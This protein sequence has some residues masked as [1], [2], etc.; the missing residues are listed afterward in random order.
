[1]INYFQKTNILVKEKI[2]MDNIMK[3]SFDKVVIDGI[4]DM[5]F[6]MRV[7][8]GTEFVYDFLN[9]SAMEKTGL[10]N[11]I[12]CKI[13]DIYPPERADFLCNQYMEVVIK[14]EKTIFEDAYISEAGERFF[15]EITLNP[16]L[17]AEG[18]CHSIIAIVKDSTL[19]KRALM[20]VQETL[21]K[22]SE[23]NEYYQSLFLHNTDGIL[24]FN[25]NGIIIKSNKAIEEILGYS[26]LELIGKSFEE[27]V[28]EDAE[29]LDHFVLQ[30]VSGNTNAIQTVIQHKSGTIVDISFKIVPLIV[31][32][33]VIGIYGILRDITALIKAAEKLEK[34]EK[35]FRIMAEN[36][37]DLIT[38]INHE[39]NITYVSPSYERVLGYSQTDFIGKDLFHNIRS[40]DVE[41]LK[42]KIENSIQT[43]ESFNVIFRQY[44]NNGEL[45]WF[46][47][48]GRPV[49]DHN[50]QFEYLVVQTRDINLR[51]EY[52]S[53]LKY[54]A[55]HDS[56]TG[57][58]NRMLFNEEFMVAKENFQKSKDGLAL[59][60]LDIDCFKLINDTFGHDV[61]DLVIKEFSQRIRKTIRDVDIVARL[62]G[63]EFV[64][65][66]TG[67]QSN[68]EV[69]QIAEN[70]LD[71]MQ[72]TWE[73]D[74]ESLTVTTSMGIAIVQA[75][76]FS[77][78]SL[79][80]CAD[81][82][83]YEAKESGRNSYRFYVES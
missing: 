15:S 12:G 22:L 69:A 67:F 8:N 5:V 73:I 51:K 41:A 35:R 36:A 50:G 79:I 37:H 32:E 55:Y 24:L 60:M 71:A 83:L 23:S 63:D 13:R 80:K 30:A 74:N 52:E 19:E 29:T 20:E 76:E 2:M 43:G 44:T 33:K 10:T 26:T 40:E 57:L 49:F 68:N 66:L 38:L 58:P 4:S 61:G 54:F 70:I 14:R 62:G 39:G 72:D 21:D 1:M 48:N 31:K 46:E 81:L 82:A 28:G 9:R 18:V 75:E 42:E 3:M 6:V 27:I 7:E 77:R 34:S 25:L 59:I 11:V 45:L 53:K 78:H 65:L 56:L 47:S 64:I 17:N 16:I